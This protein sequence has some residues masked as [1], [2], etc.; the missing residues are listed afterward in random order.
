MYLDLSKQLV[1][2]GILSKVG[3]DSLWKFFSIL[4]A[5]IIMISR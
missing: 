4:K 1:L 3:E 2:K 5:G